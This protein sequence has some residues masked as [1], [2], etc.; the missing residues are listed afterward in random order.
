MN[1]K[2][3]VGVFVLATRTKPKRYFGVRGFDTVMTESP[4]DVA[5]V[6]FRRYAVEGRKAAT[7]ATGW[8]VELWDRL[9]KKR[10]PFVAEKLEGA[11]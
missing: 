3:S 6:V 11:S 8:H 7:G 2:T 4:T 9:T 1:R 5:T 10:S